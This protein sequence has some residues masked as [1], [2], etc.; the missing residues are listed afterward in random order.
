MWAIT[1]LFFF[2]S[3]LLSDVKACRSAGKVPFPQKNADS[4][5]GFRFALL[6][7]FIVIYEPEK[8]WPLSDEGNTYLAAKW[9]TLIWQ[10]RRPCWV[11]S[12]GRKLRRCKTGQHRHCCSHRPGW[13]GCSCCSEGDSRYHWLWLATDRLPASGGWIHY[14]LPK[15]WGNYLEKAKINNS[16]HHFKMAAQTTLVFLVPKSSA[17][18]KTIPT[19][20]DTQVLSPPTLSPLPQLAWTKTFTPRYVE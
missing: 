5:L 2:S 7:Y 15:C 3:P 13:S 1:A 9:C 6:S 12:E 11:Q 8:W 16:L 4:W 14:A 17:K 19:S 20:L 18:L 10:L